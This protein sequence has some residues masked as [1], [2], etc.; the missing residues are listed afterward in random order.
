MEEKQQDQISGKEEYEARKAEKLKQIT[1]DKFT[2]KVIYETYGKEFF[3][4]DLKIPEKEVYNF[5]DYCK[6]FNI[7]DL[8]NKGLGLQVAVLLEREAPNYLRKLKQ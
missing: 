8:H 4:D 2:S 5:I 1:S 6:Q 7:K 3:V